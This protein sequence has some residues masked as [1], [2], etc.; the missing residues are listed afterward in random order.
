MKT[1]LQKFLPLFALASCF[2]ATS[3]FASEDMSST[4]KAQYSVAPA[5]NPGGDDALAF[6]IQAAYTFWV[7]YQEGMNFASSGNTGTATIA[8]NYLTPSINGCSGFKVGIGANTMHDGWMVGLNYAW[9]YNNP[10]ILANS[11]IDGTTYTATFNDSGVTYRKPS[12]Q[13]TGQFNRIDGQLDRSFYAGHYLTFRPWLGLLGAWETQNVNL[14]E[15]VSAPLPMNNWKQ[16]WWAIGPYA[17]CEASFFFT[18]E[19]AMYISSGAS[20]LLATHT[21]T[22]LEKSNSNGVFSYNLADTF[23]NV[24]PMMETSLGLRWDSYWTDWALCIDLS[25]ELQTYFSHNGF[26]SFDNPMGLMGNYSMQG[27]TAGARVSF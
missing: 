19:W 20:M 17:G 6:Y 18:N 26:Q 14:F 22:Q 15:T 13:W 1:K 2:T 7:P 23:Y 3:V 4:P 9:F 12:S 5:K 10:T 16:N 11:L 25:W 21:L 8:G 27:V 24:E